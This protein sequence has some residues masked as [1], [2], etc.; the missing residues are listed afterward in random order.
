MD[1]HSETSSEFQKE[2][3]LGKSLDYQMAKHSAWNWDRLMGYC[4]EKN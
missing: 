3:N 1:L 4:S 2:K